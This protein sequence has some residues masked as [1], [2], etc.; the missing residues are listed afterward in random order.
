MSR[1]IMLQI[2]EQD[3]Q[4]LIKREA[5]NSRGGNFMFHSQQLVTFPHALLSCSVTYGNIHCTW[6]LTKC[7][8]ASSLIFIFNSTPSKNMHPYYKI[9]MK[10]LS[11]G[12]PPDCNLRYQHFHVSGK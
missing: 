3:C 6:S 7:E 10:W 5:I 1:F 2:S 4:Y 12:L 11:K 8:T 9:Q